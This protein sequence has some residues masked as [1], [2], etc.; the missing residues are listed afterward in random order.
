M[1]VYHYR[2]WGRLFPSLLLYGTGLD[3]RSRYDYADKLL[4]EE[5]GAFWLMRVIAWMEGQAHLL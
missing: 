1:T 3:L 5:M 4:L 2:S